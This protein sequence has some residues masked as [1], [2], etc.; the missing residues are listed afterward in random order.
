MTSHT[1]ESRD[2]ADNAIKDSEA[3]PNDNN[4]DIEPE[5]ADPNRACH[6]GN[7]HTE[8][9]GNTHVCQ[10]DDTPEAVE[11]SELDAEKSQNDHQEED[12]KEQCLLIQIPVPRKWTLLRSGLGTIAY[13]GVPVVKND[14]NNSL[15]GKLRIS[16]GKIEIKNSFCYSNI[17]HRLPQ[18]SI[19]WKIPFISNQDLRR[20][21][22]NLL[23]G[24]HLPQSEHHQNTRWMKNKYVEVLPGP[25]ALINFERA[26]VPRRP[27]RVYYHQSLTERIT[28]G[29]FYKLGDTKK[30]DRFHIFVRPMFCI[31]RAQYQITISRQSFETQ[32][33]R[34]H[35]MPIVI[36]AINSCWKYLCPICGDS[37]TNL[38]AFR[39]HSCSIPW[40]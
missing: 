22:L 40:N 36:I 37:F 25:N 19:T 8:R 11:C 39:E 31:P 7:N 27:L 24:K 34:S 5:V 17:N 10:E 3:T 38:I 29:H 26:L 15:T 23:C 6:M 9:E 1:E 16:S 28:P 2:P 32:K 4:T 13:L 12:S 20:M 18:L 30:K 35:Y 21:I 14:N 33:L